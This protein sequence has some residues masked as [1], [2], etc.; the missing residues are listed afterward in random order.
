MN[1]GKVID[2]LMVIA[3]GVAGGIIFAFWIAGYGQP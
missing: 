1:K 3:F 2:W